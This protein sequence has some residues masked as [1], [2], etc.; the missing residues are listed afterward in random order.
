MKYLMTDTD[1]RGIVRTYF[2]RNGVKIRLPGDPRTREFRA[3]YD[4]ALKNSHE[5]LLRPK[6]AKPPKEVTIRKTGYVYFLKSGD[7][8]KI[9]YSNNPI[10]RAAGIKTG[11]TGAVDFMICIPGTRHDERELHRKFAKGRSNGEWFKIGPYFYDEMTAIIGG[12]RNKKGQWT[13]PPSDAVTAPP[14]GDMQNVQ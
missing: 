5:G 6:G 1:R 2:R 4:E 10:A 12:K 9:G 7:F 8:F 13:A 14:Q 3:A 11:M